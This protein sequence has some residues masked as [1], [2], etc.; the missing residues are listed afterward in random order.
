[1]EKITF[2]TSAEISQV[3][4]MA[5]RGVRI[6]IDTPELPPEDMARLFNLKKPETI[7]WVAF[8]DMPLQEKDLEIP[9][10]LD[11]DIDTKSPSQRLRNVLFRY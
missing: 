3:K 2:Q 7:V 4:T 11:K 6:Q 5:D 9:E 1:M 8:K 10:V